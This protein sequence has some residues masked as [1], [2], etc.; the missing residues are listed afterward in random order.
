MQWILKELCCKSVLFFKI[1]PDSLLYENL[2]Q[3]ILFLLDGFN[4]TYSFL[5]IDYLTAKNLD[6]ASKN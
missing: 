5:S 6:A 2:L 1:L 4:L 3:A